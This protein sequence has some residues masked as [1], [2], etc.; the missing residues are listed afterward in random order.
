M[1]S[2]VRPRPSIKEQNNVSDSSTIAANTNG[3]DDA[4]QVQYNGMAV[5]RKDNNRLQLVSGRALP[6]WVWQKLFAPVKARVGKIP[7]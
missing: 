7:T 2:E 3:A 1:S 4:T 5:K 6:K